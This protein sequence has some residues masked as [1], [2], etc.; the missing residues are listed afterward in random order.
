M[1]LPFTLFAALAVVARSQAAA[2]SLIEVHIAQLLVQSHGGR[3]VLTF[4]L[5]DTHG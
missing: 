4:L 1:H 5:E 2:E 3:T